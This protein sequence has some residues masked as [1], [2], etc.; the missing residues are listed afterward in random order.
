M[1]ASSETDAIMM[2]ANMM[3]FINDYEDVSKTLAVKMCLFTNM[4]PYDD[5]EITRMVQKE[6]NMA[7]ML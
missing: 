4:N 7:D 1:N 2:G 3:G 5:L 6:K